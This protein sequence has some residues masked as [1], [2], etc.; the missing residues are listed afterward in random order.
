MRHTLS[1]LI[2]QVWTLKKTC[3]LCQGERTI[4]DRFVD[5][6]VRGAQRRV[7]SDLRIY[8]NRVLSSTLNTKIGAYFTGFDIEN[9]NSI[10]S[11]VKP[12]N[13]S[14]SFLNQPDLVTI[15]NNCRFVDP[16]LLF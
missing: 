3:I 10:V 16:N 14:G 7:Y 5:L 12:G 9:P 6:N 15:K 8:R 13:I 11:M 1:K 4:F 2:V